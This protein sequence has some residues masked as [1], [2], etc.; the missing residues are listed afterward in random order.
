MKDSFPQRNLYSA[1]S[2]NHALDNMQVNQKEQFM[3]NRESSVHYSSSLFDFGNIAKEY[4]RWYRT[5][6]GRIHD[7]LQKADVLSLLFPPQDHESLL[8]VGCG[9]GHWSKFF[10][11]LGY[12]VVGVDISQKM[13]EAADSQ[14][15]SDCIFQVSDAC[16]LPFEERS[17]D[18]VTAM[19]TLEFVSD[20][21][22]ALQEMFR[23]VKENGRVLAGTLNRLAPINQQRLAEKREPYISARLFSPEEFYNVLAPF[24]S[25][26]MVASSPTD[27]GVSPWIEKPGKHRM[28]PDDLHIQ[29]PFIVAEIKP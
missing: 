16:C 9:T 2:H 7:L 3:S 11:A 18:I 15:T 22:C 26:R 12:R 6:E 28:I 17:F 13:I 27:G 23:C 21:L 20:V 19:A 25:V 10:A 14:D 24:G 29:G 1:Y 4:D 5:S 8:D